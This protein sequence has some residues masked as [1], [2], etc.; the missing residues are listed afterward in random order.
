M[1]HPST[2]AS[3]STTATKTWASPSPRT[4]CCDRCRPTYRAGGEVMPDPDRAG[5]IGA[6]MF[7]LPGSED[8]T[9][10][11]CCRKTKPTGAVASAG[12][13]QEPRRTVNYLGMVTAGPFAEPDSLR[14]DSHMLVTVAARGGN[15][16]PPYHGRVQV[17]DSRRGN[18]AT[19]RWPRRDCGRCPTAR[20]SR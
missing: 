6:T 12:A 20:W 5:A 13:H 3:A 9:V 7:D 1:P 19:A 2:G 15:Y 11:S 17:V 16:L 18:G 14:A 4:T 10:T 8:H